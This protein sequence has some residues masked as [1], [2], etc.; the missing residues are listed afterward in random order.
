MNKNLIKRLHSRLG[1]WIKYE[2]K[3]LLALTNNPNLRQDKFIYIDKRDGLNHL[4][5]NITICSRSTLSRIENGQVV[6]DSSIVNIFLNRFNKKFRINEV[7][8]H[9]I[10]SCIQAFYVYLLQNSKISTKYLSVILEDTNFKVKDNFLW[11]EDYKV[12]IKI[13]KW[14][15]SFDIL[16][17]VELKDFISKFEFYHESL[18]VILI[19]YL[20]F[21]VY[22]NPELWGYHIQISAL[23]NEKFS[24]DIFL[25]MFHLLF[26]K[27]EAIVIR[28]FY[29]LND[30][31]NSNS[32]LNQILMIFKVMFIHSYFERDYLHLKYISLVHKIRTINY[33]PQDNYENLIFHFLNQNRIEDNSSIEELL[34]MIKDEPVP[35]VV[36]RL[37]LQKMVPKVRTKNQLSIILASLLEN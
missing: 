8:Q 17:E 36:N 6:Y 28:S 1:Y 14:Y 26:N 35:R 27:N 30:Q 31:L 12:L 29:Q 21:S 33:T 5:Q 24:D 7:D 13:V 11:N 2:R 9:L 3:R 37:V 4:D 10:D 22:F 15:Q 23:I 18:Q 20:G 16:D 19:Y 34:L 32:F 25:Q